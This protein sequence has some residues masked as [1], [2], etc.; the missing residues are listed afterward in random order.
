MEQYLIDYKN[1]K[2]SVGEPLIN[3][4]KTNP[5][6]QLGLAIQKIQNSIRGKLT[7]DET[8]ASLNDFNYKEFEVEEQLLFLFQLFSFYF[9]NARISSA[10]SIY[11]IMK[12]ITSANLAPEFQILHMQAKIELSGNLGFH[13][14]RLLELENC[15]NILGKKSGRFK[16]FIWV[17][18]YELLITGNYQKMDEYLITLNQLHLTN[19]RDCAPKFLIFLRKLDQGYYSENYSKTDFL[20]EELSVPLRNSSDYFIYREDFIQIFEKCNFDEFEKEKERDYPML[21][22]ISLL[23]KD[24]KKALFYAQKDLEVFIPYAATSAFI[25]YYLIRAELANGNIIAAEYFLENKRRLQS[26]SMFDDY[27]W[28]HIYHSKG[29]KIKAQLYFDQYANNADRFDFNRR[30]DVEIRLSPEIS[31]TDIRKYSQNR[32]KNHRTT[33]NINPI[34]KFV[35]PEENAFDLLVGESPQISQM[36]LLVK[37]YA[38]VDTTILV[39]GETGTGK[40]LVAKALWKSGHYSKNPFIPINCGAISDHLLQTELF[41]HKKGAFTGAIQDHKGI[42][43]EAKNGVVFLDEIGEISAQMQVSLLR[44]LE[45][46]E[47][48]PVGSS[49]NKKIKCKIIAA[50]NRKLTDHVKSGGFRQ[51]LQYRLERLTIEVPALRD[52]TSDIPAL[53]NHFLNK[54][55]PQLPALSF[56]NT[57]LQ[58]LTQLPW[59]GNIRELKNEMEKIRLFYSDKKILTVDELSEKY[60]IQFKSSKKSSNLVDEKSMLNHK[61]KFRKLEELKLLFQTQKS[62]S[63]IE[64]AS[65]LKVSNNTAANYLLTLE[66]EKFIKKITLNNTKSNHYE[67]Y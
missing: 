19:S 2:S 63:R 1:G 36:K 57:A 58:F 44:V 30:F 64:V 55:N 60:K 8:I 31:L 43:E 41:G 62:L 9:Y 35:T 52:R 34:E 42:F 54:L 33:L 20:Q 28:F 18:L 38:S 5:H 24:S 21:S 29:D 37:K 47:F 53:I 46:G 12:S 15:L 23:K 65:F 16:L 11:S 22:T 61:S 59:Q 14:Q 27:F 39:V 51:D 7:Y 40:E 50:T 3:F 13:R 17:Y 66:N 6:H 49:E 32:K 4:L 48:R 56:D 25:S 67:I 45:S 10:K 26:E